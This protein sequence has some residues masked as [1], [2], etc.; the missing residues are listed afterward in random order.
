MIL[1]RDVGSQIVSPR[2]GLS[3]RIVLTIL[4]LFAVLPTYWILATALTPRDQVFAVDRPLIPHSITLDNFTSLRQNSALVNN[5]VNSIIVSSATAILSTIVSVFMAYSFSKFRYRGRSSLMILLLTGQLFPGSLLLIALYVLFQNLGL[6]Y[7]YTGVVLAF[8]TFTLP[9]TVF[10]LKSFLD[11]IPTGLIEAARLDG[12][13]QLRIIGKIVLPLAAP[14]LIASALFAF[15]R[16]WNDLLFALTLAG[17]DKQTLPAGLVQT[18]IVEGQADWPRLMG[19]SVLT[20][21]PIVIIF[22]VL[23][24]YLLSGL[25]LG[26]V[27]G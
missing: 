20:A 25:A 27:K 26:A 14:G 7:T 13:S 19:A 10:V 16:G 12:A 17:P 6:L 9:L 23:Q 8:T 1:Q 11:G 3:G 15:V 5:L 18:F 4:S 22:V 21:F 24:R 2:P